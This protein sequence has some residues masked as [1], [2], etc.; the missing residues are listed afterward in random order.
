MP[1]ASRREAG[2]LFVLWCC[3]VADINHT[4]ETIPKDPSRCGEK[5]AGILIVLCS[6]RYQNACRKPLNPKPLNP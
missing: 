6:G 3:A 4:H 1:K 5:E 2:I